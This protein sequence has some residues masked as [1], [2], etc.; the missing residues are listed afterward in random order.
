MRT[1]ENDRDS[2]HTEERDGGGRGGG[3]CSKFSRCQSEVRLSLSRERF[4]GEWL[5]RRTCPDYKPYVTYLPLP[6]LRLP[7]FLHECVWVWVWVWVCVCVGVFLRLQCVCVVT[8]LGL[9]KGWR[10][11]FLEARARTPNKDTGPAR[12]CVCVCARACVGTGMG[13]RLCMCVRVCVCVE[14]GRILMGVGEWNRWE[15]L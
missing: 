15:C 11:R 13:V 12:A 3:P 1:N 6:C 10:L 9:V 5:E 2:A 7:H 4:V 14:T 8:Y